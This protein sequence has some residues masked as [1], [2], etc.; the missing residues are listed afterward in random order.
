MRSRLAV[1]LGF[2]LA[3]STTGSFGEGS[4][5]DIRDLITAERSFASL[6]AAKGVREAFLTYLADEAIIFRPKPTLGRPVYEQMPADAP[7]LLTWGSAFAEVAAAGDWGYTTGPYEVMDR[8][9]PDQASRHGHYVSI[10]KKQTGGQWKVV[11]DAGISHSRPGVL[12][13]EVATPKSVGKAKKDAAPDL[14]EENLALLKAELAFANQ[15]KAAGL[16]KAYPASAAEDIRFFREGSFPGA[17]RE[18]L[19][20]VLRDSSGICTWA[21]QEK[22]ISLS[23]DLAY[24]YGIS[25]CKTGTAGPTAPESSSFLRIWR[26]S[27][28]GRWTIALDLAIPIP[29]E[30]QKK[31]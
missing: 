21:V 8:S 28:D 14:E 23:G 2:C 17:G 24:V 10:W 16:A 15:A 22:Q 5:Q 31:E 25:D 19:E 3:I 12:P 29:S 4:G 20:E 6:A 13:D 18:S 30:V 11:L 27:A 9:R 7:L 1:L 26:K